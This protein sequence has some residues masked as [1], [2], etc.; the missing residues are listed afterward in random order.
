MV[1][2]I[3]P[4]VPPVMGSSTVGPNYTRDVGAYDVTSRVTITLD[5]TVTPEQLAAW[6]RDVRHR[7]LPRRYRPQQIKALRLAR[8][9]ARSSP[10][11]TWDQDRRRWNAGI[12]ETHPH[13]RYDDVANFRRHLKEAVRRLLYVG[14]QSP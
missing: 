13:W 10:D 4:Y 6:W 8:F 5:P 9:A 12:S 14:I 11:T 3:D 2:G 7:M 1:S